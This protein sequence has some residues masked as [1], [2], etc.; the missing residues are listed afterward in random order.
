MEGTPV[1]V[2]VVGASCASGY[3]FHAFFNH[4]FISTLKGQKR[5]RRLR[6]SLS[7]NS[8]PRSMSPSLR[9]FIHHVIRPKC[10]SRCSYKTCNR[11]WRPRRNPLHLFT[12]WTLWGFQRSQQ[13]VEECTWVASTGKGREKPVVCRSIKN[14]NF[15][16]LLTVLLH[17]QRV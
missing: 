5:R 15:S 1:V 7:S 17:Q 11:Q 16:T 9:I 2:P 8:S 13:K 6:V 4:R 3:R 14:I 12:I 10:P